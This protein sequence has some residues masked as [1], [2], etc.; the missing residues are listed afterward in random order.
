MQEYL[1]NIVDPILPVR[2]E[3]LNKQVDETNNVFNEDIKLQ[4]LK[5]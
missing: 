3:E 4:E 1:Y 5:E 2:L